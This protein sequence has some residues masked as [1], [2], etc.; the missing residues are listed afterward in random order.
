[1]PG[2]LLRLSHTAEKQHRADEGAQNVHA[3]V[4]QGIGAGLGM[5]PAQKPQKQTAEGQQDRKSESFVFFF[6]ICNLLIQ[7]PEKPAP[8]GRLL[9]L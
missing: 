3:H 6:S 1:M 4:K 8:K 5:V 7:L 2:R 9:R